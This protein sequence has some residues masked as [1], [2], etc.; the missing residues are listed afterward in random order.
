ME[1]PTGGDDLPGQ[2]G[3]FIVCELA[4][5]W[6]WGGHCCGSCTLTVWAHCPYIEKPGRRQS[7]V[8]MALGNIVTY[9][10]TTLDSIWIY[11][12]RNKYRNGWNN[13]NQMLINYLSLAD[14]PPV[15]HPAP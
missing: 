8:M 15:P 4:G 6:Q 9:C 12:Y 7:D 11:K 13:P 3:D 1:R 10:I 14:S 2:I 5:V